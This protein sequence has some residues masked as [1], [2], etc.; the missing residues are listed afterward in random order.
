MTSLTEVIRF[1]ALVDKLTDT[2]FDQFILTLVQKC[3]RELRGIL[4]TSLFA[5]FASGCTESKQ[6][7]KNGTDKVQFQFAK[8]TK[9]LN[10]GREHISFLSSSLESTPPAAAHTLYN[11]LHAIREKSTEHP[12]MKRTYATANGSRNRRNR[13]IKAASGKKLG[14]LRMTEQFQAHLKKRKEK[15]EE[16]QK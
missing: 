12:G 9:Q 3:G 16:E 10:P 2:E 4:I 11:K 13:A 5:M 1:R 15:E 8:K 6:N 14:H 7:I